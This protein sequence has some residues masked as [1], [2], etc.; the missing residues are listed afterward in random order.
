MNILVVDDEPLARAELSY[1]IKE[2]PSLQ[3]QDRRFY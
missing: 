1:L 2:S 3:E